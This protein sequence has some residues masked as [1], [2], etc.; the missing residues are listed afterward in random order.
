MA[1]RDFKVHPVAAECGHG[2]AGGARA[3]SLGLKTHAA[4][5]SNA[6]RA[7]PV[8]LRAR[9][10]ALGAP[11]LHAAIHGGEYDANRALAR[12]VTRRRPCRGPL[13]S[14]APLPRAAPRRTLVAPEGGLAPGDA[15]GR[16]QR[17]KAAL[18]QRCLGGGQR[19]GRR[20]RERG[21]LVRRGRR[22]RGQRRRGRGAPP[23]RARR[24]AAGGG[25]GG[26]GRAAGGGRRA[27]GRHR[28]RQQR[29]GSLASWSAI[30]FR[31]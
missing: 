8:A 2:R 25:R 28:A 3:S 1:P 24:G 19:E 13:A 21:H 11:A 12:G 7:R 27:E 26:G 9:G 22:R 14:G 6:R 17:A 18:S 23:L 20:G 30:D 4:A 15:R 5:S 10:A 31:P 16:Q 29:P